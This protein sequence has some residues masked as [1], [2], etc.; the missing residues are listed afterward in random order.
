[1]SP[2]IGLRDRGLEPK[3]FEAGPALPGQLSKFQSLAL[4]FGHEE[5]SNTEP[6][7]PN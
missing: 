7:G 5:P 3:E 6:E 2:Q 1:M 4:V